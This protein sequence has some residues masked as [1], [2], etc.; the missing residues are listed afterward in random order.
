MAYAISSRSTGIL[1]NKRAARVDRAAAP[2]RQTTLLSDASAHAASAPLL[3][4]HLTPSTRAALLQVGKHRDYRPGEQLF[5]QG[6]GHT[7]IFLI[8]TGLV[9]SYYVSED[10]R[11]LTLGFW[12]AGHYVGAPQMFGAGQHEWASVAVEHTRCLFLP[13]PELRLL[14]NDYPDLALG[15]IDALV[16]K[17]LCYSALLQLLA[18]QSMRAR[19]GRLLSMLAAR[20]PHAGIG[21]THSELA[22]MVGSTRQWVSL[23]LARFEEEG[24]LEKRANGSYR[25]ID[26]AALERVR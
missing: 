22:G 3:L 1:P 24:M 11:E 13:G 21:L 12:S 17:S 14:C 16:H 25:V 8:E 10:G 20:E 2:L 19:L 5:H 7:G 26:T 6:A 15:L 18:T 4:E 9:K 23:S